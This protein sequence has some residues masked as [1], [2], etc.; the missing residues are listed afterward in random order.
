MLTQ[1][2]CDLGLLKSGEKTMLVMKEK[3]ILTNYSL[4]TCKSQC[5]CFRGKCIYTA[6]YA[7]SWYDTKSPQQVIFYLPWTD[8][9]CSLSF[10]W[11]PGSQ[12]WQIKTSY[13][14]E[15][16]SVWIKNVSCYFRACYNELDCCF[17]GKRGGQ[18]RKEKVCCKKG[19][20]LKCPE[21]WMVT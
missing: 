4:R 20:A 13:A 17:T 19:S 6:A 2:W 21:C 3:A 1:K 12:I 9:A 10:W 8:I 11:L 14:S 7:C 18:R 5:L 15:N 16:G